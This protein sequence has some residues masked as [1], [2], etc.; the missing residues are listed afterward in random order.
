MQNTLFMR[1]IARIKPT[2]ISP[3][4]SSAMVLVLLAFPAS[5][6]A[7]TGIVALEAGQPATH[8]KEPSTMPKAVPIHTPQVMNTTYHMP[9]TMRQR[10]DNAMHS[11]SSLY[12]IPYGLLH[13]ISLTESGAWPWTLNVY[14]VPYYF[15]NAQQTEAAVH[16]F[17]QRQID[18]VDIGPMQVDWQYHGWHFGSVKAAVNPLRNIAVAGRI[19]KKNFTET[20]SWRK[21]VGLYHGG[22]PARQE[23]YIQKVYSHWSDARANSPVEEPISLKMPTRIPHSSSIVALQS[24]L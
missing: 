13:A 10:M 15:K 9:K 3:M 6:F 22:G 2:N 7:C 12:G 18:L 1:K 23:N 11:I 17:L 19:L 8:F 24:P 4:K 14:G 5:S 20:G 21:A 16:R